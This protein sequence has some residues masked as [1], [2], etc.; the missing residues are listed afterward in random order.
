MATVG[1]VM[2]RR[3]V[4]RVLQVPVGR[5]RRLA[6]ALTARL[7]EV[8]EEPE[9]RVQAADRLERQIR[10]EGRPTVGLRVVVALAI[11]ELGRMVEPVAW[12]QVVE[13][14]LALQPPVEEIWLE[15]RQLV[16]EIRPV[17]RMRVEVVSLVM[18][19]RVAVAG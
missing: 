16:A 8:V 6:V 1:E 12:L 3:R 2:V 13:I 19:L 9:L 15:V 5:G 11:P 14:L 4:K 18:S 7:L 17:V 10:V